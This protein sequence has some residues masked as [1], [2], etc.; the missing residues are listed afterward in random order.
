[1]PLKAHGDT[2]SKLAEMQVATGSAQQPDKA[3]ND[4]GSSV[5]ESKQEEE[6]TTQKE[7]E[8]EEA[9]TQGALHSSIQPEPEERDHTNKGILC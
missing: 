2:R 5:Q 9:R 1:M 4:D 8:A 3:A 6:Q 7:Q